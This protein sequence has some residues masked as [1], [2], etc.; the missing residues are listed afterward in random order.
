MDHRDRLNEANYNYELGMR[1]TTFTVY[2]YLNVAQ[3]R[4]QIKLVST[5]G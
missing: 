2:V 1:I 4:E 3:I 5:I